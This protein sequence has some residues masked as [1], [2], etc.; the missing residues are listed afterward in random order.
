[1]PDRTYKLIELVGVSSR[2]FSDA[3]NNAVKKA[4]QTLKGIGWI[5]VVEQ[6]GAV[7]DGKLAEYQVKVR[8]AFRLMGKDE[9]EGDEGAGAGRKGRR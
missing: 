9:L 5:E 3:A 8:V 1:M 6:R 2:S 4:S 7:R